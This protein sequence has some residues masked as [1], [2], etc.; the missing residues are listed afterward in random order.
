MKKVDFQKR[1]N[2]G[3]IYLFIMVE[4]KRKTK[5]I[6]RI[7]KMVK[8]MLRKCTLIFMKKSQKNTV[9]GVPTWK[10]SSGGLIKFR[11]KKCHFSRQI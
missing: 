1:L 6:S 7:L 8:I 9:T 11:I 3:L 2:Q 4:N 10:K 5:H